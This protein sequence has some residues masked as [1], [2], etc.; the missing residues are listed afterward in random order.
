MQHSLKKTRFESIGAYVPRKS[1]TTKELIARM[2]IPPIFDLEDLTG[3]KERRMRS[4]S[5]DSFTIALEAVKDCLKNSK[6]DASD[7]D[8]IITT[9]ITRFKD[10][11]F[12]YEPTMT[13]LLKNALGVRRAMNFDMSNACA[14]MFTGVYVLDNLIK[15]GVVKRG[16]VVSGECI[17]PITDT[18]IK[19]ISEPID[20][21]FA[22]LTVGDAGACV[23]M[24]ESPSDEDGYIWDIELRTFSEFAEMCLG[25]PSIK[26][27]GVAMYAKAMEIQAEVIAR[28]PKIIKAGIDDW[29]KRASQF[30][31]V[32]PH[33]TSTRAMQT[34]LHKI[35]KFCELE[36]MPECMYIVHKYGNTAST[37]HF[38]GF[39]DYIKSKA[40]KKGTTVLA[41]VLGSGIT[42]GHVSIKFGSMGSMRSGNEHDD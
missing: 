31:F 36:T 26:N 19:E 39:H 27:E 16:M 34:A 18:A 22:S 21:Q 42:M 29:G 8:V 14:G 33:Q 25:K 10:G 9:Q 5:E 28:V 17:T 24:D 37:S 13:Q 23:I 12:L 1:V 32:I 38:V 40:I 41:I 3:I 11:K 2:A 30:N 35:Q 20:D 15:A 6:Y 4:E 7:M